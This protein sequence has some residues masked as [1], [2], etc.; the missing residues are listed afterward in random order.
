MIENGDQGSTQNF[1]ARL[2]SIVVWPGEPFLRKCSNFK[3]CMLLDSAMSKKSRNRNF[4]GTNAPQGA[5]RHKGAF[6]N[7]KMKI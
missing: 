7:R 5:S 3:K 2:V 1:D 4:S 6:Q